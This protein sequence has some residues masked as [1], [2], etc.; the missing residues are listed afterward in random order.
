[1]DAMRYAIYTYN[2]DYGA[3]IEGDKIDI[4]YWE[5]KFNG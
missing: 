4:L 1:M 2:R 5:V 3:T